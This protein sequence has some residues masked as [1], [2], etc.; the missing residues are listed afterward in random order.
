M[1]GRVVARWDE[2]RGDRRRKEVD[3]IGSLR[4]KCKERKMSEKKDE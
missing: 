1:R 3:G 4:E 2:R